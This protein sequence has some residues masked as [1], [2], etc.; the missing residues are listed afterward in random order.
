MIKLRGSSFDTWYNKLN[1]KFFVFSY[2]GIGDTIVAANFAKYK[3]AAVVRFVDVPFANDFVKKYLEMLKI[4]YYLLD[5]KNEANVKTNNKYAKVDQFH[6]HNQIK[7]PEKNKIM[8][9][10][11]MMNHGFVK[12]NNCLPNVVFICPMGSN[13]TKSIPS[14]RYIDKKYFD[15]IVEKLTKKGHDIYLVGIEKDIQEY[16]FPH[17]CKWINSNE[18]IY[19]NNVK[20]K[21]NMEIFMQ[22]VANAK[23]AI[24]A[25]TS[26]PLISCMLNVKT[27]TI[28]RY[29]AENRPIIKDM[30]D[31]FNSF[32]YNPNY[33][34]TLTMAD[35]PKL[36]D[37]VDSI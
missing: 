29:N 7:G 26:F 9:S 17:N 37:L 31:V 1:N 23:L 4:D 15:I 19:S 25:P 24:A 36:M 6:F 13:N 32:F 28:Y 16:G 10:I 3:N 30:S 20:Q 21:I 18:I 8:S 35:Y 2:K 11:Y 34:K 33:Y 12:Q 14:R 22:M 27:W 5:R